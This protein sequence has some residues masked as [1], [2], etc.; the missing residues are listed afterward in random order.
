MITH[1]LKRDRAKEMSKESFNA[2]KEQCWEKL[3]EGR[4][5]YGDSFNDKDIR[6]ELIG[7]LIDVAN[8]AYMLTLKVKKMGVG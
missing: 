3:E 2:F 6:D 4:K 5:K 7:E 8:Y 1:E